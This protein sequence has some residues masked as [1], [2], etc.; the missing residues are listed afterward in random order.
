[1]SKISSLRPLGECAR[2]DLGRRT[3]VRGS[4]GRDKLEGQL[5]LIAET[6]D[7]DDGDNGGLD[8]LCSGIQWEKE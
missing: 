3:Q 8:W 1:M 5:R 6:F 2:E 4:S 7:G